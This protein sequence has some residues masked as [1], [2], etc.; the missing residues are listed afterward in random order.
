MPL[1]FSGFRT[2][3]DARE[4]WTPPK[5]TGPAIAAKAR[6]QETHPDSA[7]GSMQKDQPVRVEVAQKEDVKDQKK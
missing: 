5:S 2:S 4:R 1:G 6:L 7:R 3:Q